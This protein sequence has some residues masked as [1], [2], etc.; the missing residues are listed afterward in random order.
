MKYFPLIWSGLWRRRARTMLTFL[1]IAVAFVLFGILHGV[2]LAFDDV[3]ERLGDDRLRTTSRTNALEPLPLA[4]LS[5][6]ETVAGVRDVAFYSVFPATL[7]QSNSR[8]INVG[9]IDIDRF[10]R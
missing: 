4:Y 5:Q 9:A 1:S 2:T 8:A 3:I 7:D 10:F 6:I